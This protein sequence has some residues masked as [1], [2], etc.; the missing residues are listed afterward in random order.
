MERMKKKYV[1]TGGAG[2]IGSHLCDLLIE[3]GHSVVCVDDL[4]TGT[5]M[6]VGHLSRNE[7][8][9][10]VVGD[11]LDRDLMD[12]EI[13]AADGVFHVAAVVGMKLA[14][15]APLRT[16]E[17]NVFG[18]H[19]VM[20]MCMKYQKDL[21]LV[22][23]SEVYGHSTDCPT[24]ETSGCVM[25]Q[26]N[27]RRWSYAASKMIDE[28]FALALY[29]QKGLPVRVVRI[30]NTV[31]PRQSN[32]YGMVIPTFVQNA[33]DGFPLRV[34][35]DGSQRR[36]FGHVKDVAWALSKLMESE[37]AMGLVV[38]VGGHDEVSIEELAAAVIERAQSKS[39]IEFVPFDK[40]YMPG[41]EE[42]DRR[43]PDLTLLRQLT[44]YEPKYSL[45]DVVDEVIQERR[46]LQSLANRREGN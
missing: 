14:V 33:L 25:R 21:L 24:P 41:F 1:V 42:I 45:V 44:G 29:E 35:G 38:N 20:A 27:H 15:K 16:L 37:A 2:F 23:T 7:K 6:N 28:F 4:S 32:A 30:F 40:A 11:V 39:V 22:S 12:T 36:T 8:F 43:V 13:E 19:N 9:R 3:D 17:T 46:G 18:A 26:V 10:L 34:H 5:P 31:G